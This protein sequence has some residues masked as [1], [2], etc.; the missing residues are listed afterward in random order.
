MRQ[1]WKQQ[2]SNKNQNPCSMLSLRGNLHRALGKIENATALVFFCEKKK[3]F[4]Q[5]ELIIAIK[6]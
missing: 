6:F 2:A 4:L 1:H 5:S 3:V